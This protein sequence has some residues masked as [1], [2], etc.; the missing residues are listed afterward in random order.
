MRTQDVY[1]MFAMASALLA[2]EVRIPDVMLISLKH[3]FEY[4]TTEDIREKIAKDFG[5]VRYEISYRLRG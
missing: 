5:N 4:E 1:S 2:A 3:V